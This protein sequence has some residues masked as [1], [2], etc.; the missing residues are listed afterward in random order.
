MTDASAGAA[1][2]ERWRR[3]AEAAASPSRAGRSCTPPSARLTHAPDARPGGETAICTTTPRPTRR[4]SGNTS[5][6]TCRRLAQGHVIT[7]AAKAPTDRRS[8]PATQYQDFA[9]QPERDSTKLAHLAGALDQ[10][11]RLRATQIAT[12]GLVTIQKLVDQTVLNLAFRFARIVAQ[13]LNVRLLVGRF[14][15]YAITNPAKER[16]VG[17]SSPQVRRD[18]QHQLERHA[19]FLPG[20]ERQVVDLLLERDDP[21]VEQLGRARCAGGR[22][23]RGGKAAVGLDVRRGFVERSDGLYARSSSAMVISPPATTNGGWMRIS[24]SRLCSCRRR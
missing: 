6:G 24:A 13:D 3:R 4:S 20:G 21:A 7:S 18:D 22:S 8:T 9:G 1:L 16:R 10:I 19:D 5:P 14:D 23:R 15:V 17:E 11:A 12:L 2:P